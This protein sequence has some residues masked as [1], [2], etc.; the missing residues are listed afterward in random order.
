M[1][2]NLLF[3]AMTFENL[4]AIIGVVLSAI[5]LLVGINSF[6]GILLIIF[7]AMCIAY[8]IYII[9]RQADVL[10]YVC[11]YRCELQ[12]P[13]GKDAKITRFS[14]NKVLSRKLKTQT[15]R[16]LTA[17]GKFSNFRTNIGTLAPI[18]TQGG[19][20]NVRIL[21]DDYLKPNSLF[22]WSLSYEAKDCFKEN[23]ESVVLEGKPKMRTGIIEVSFPSERI[24][25]NFIKIVEKEGNRKTIDESIDF[26]VNTSTVMWVIPSP[27]VD[28]QYILEWEW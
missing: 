16:G 3:I 10:C 13:S 6:I 23:T 11:Y 22:N 21:F 19:D 25:S 26:D 18:Q 20:I 17:T 12:S 7:S 24:P 4:L 14:S 1:L 9:Y 15:V 2:L 5:G 8:L 27:S 28:A